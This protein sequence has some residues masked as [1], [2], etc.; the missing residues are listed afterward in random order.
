MTQHFG[1]SAFRT[2]AYN[3][4]IEP[5]AF[6]MLDADDGFGGFA[7]GLLA[8]TS[9]T[10]SHHAFVATANMRLQEGLN[11]DF[12][13]FGASGGLETWSLG[14]GR[15]GL[16][17]GRMA[18]RMLDFG[19]PNNVGD[20]RCA[21]PL[22]ES[23]APATFTGHNET[24]F[25]GPDTVG[26]I[27]P[28]IPP[29]PLI[30]TPDLIPA[31]MT[32]T[33]TLTVNGAHITSTIN[34]VGDHDWFKVDLV[35]GQTYDISQWM[36]TGG[37]SLVPLPDAYISLYDSAGNLIVNADGGGP[38]TPQGLDATLTYTAQYTGTYYVSAEAFDQDSTNGTEGDGV[39]DYEIF[40]RTV[41]PHQAG[42]YRPFYDPDQPM[43]AI[44]WGTQVDG[45]VRNPDGNNGTR[46]NDWAPD[47]TS[48][49]NNTEFGITGKNVITYYFAKTGE[50]YIDEDL[51]TLGTT[52]TM[53]AEGMEQWEKDAFRAALDQYEHVAD[54]IYLETTDRAAADFI[55]ITYEG[56][57]GAGASL[58]GRMSPPDTDNEGQAEFNAGDVRWT[59]EGLQQG[60][61]YFTTLLHEIGH[62]HGMAHP[63]DNG[64]HSSIM[65]GAGP[66]D[67]PVDGAIGGEFGDYDLSQQVFT[68]MSYND[69]WQTSPYGMPS[70]GDFPTAMNAD[71][72][73]WMGTL[74][75]LDIAVIQDK[76]GVNEEY[77]AG[78]NVYTLKDVNAAGTFY[79]TIWDGG[80]TD[81]IR[82]DG[83]ANANLDLR[84]ATLK[85]EYGGG[86]WMN[87]AYGI[88]GGYTIANGVTIENATGGSGNDS[89]TGNDAAN[90]L[91][92]RAGDDTIKAGAG[93][94]ILI[95]GAGTNSL[96]GGDGDDTFRAGSGADAMIGGAGT[97]YADYRLAGALAINL[98]TGF[99]SAA[100][101]G[102]TFNS[103]E[104]FML[105]GGDD[106][107]VVGSTG[108]TVLAGGGEDLLTG[109]SGVDDLR[110][111]DGD[112]IIS[113]ND[114][115]DLVDGGLGADWLKGGNG[116]D[117]I[118]GGDGDDRLEGGAGGDVLK[119]GLGADIL[120]G[121]SGTDTADYRGTDAVSLNLATGVHGGAAAGDTL[122]SIELY[123]LSDAGDT[124]VGGGAADYVWGN[125]GADSLSGGGGADH[126][127]GGAG[128]DVIDGGMGSDELYGGSGADM[129]VFANGFGTDKI[130]DFEDGIDHIKL[131][132][133]TGVTS[134]SNVVVTQDLFGNAVLSFGL[135]NSI[136]LQGVS[137][138]KVDASDFIFN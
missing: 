56:T 54:V 108:V 65:R 44:D 135:N 16:F 28:T 73:G 96:D 2:S 72:Y 33:Q 5:G 121:G 3:A 50:L 82:Y 128:D 120:D 122:T 111:E 58:L 94:D 131:S 64:G 71:P 48:P 81:E 40:V 11:R 77:N 35:A 126:L 101:Q 117:R 80:G 12:G 32:T 130:F 137:A 136:T 9:L 10:A 66:S 15:E 75:A 45:T 102:D 47:G 112:D 42:A 115:A 70:S 24:A 13:R 119:G 27:H 114:G 37:P 61:F 36:V 113:A 118:S 22:K 87:Y 84:A 86:G 26:D 20:G 67:D 91:D 41:D 97:D 89:I 18:G 38:N 57:P 132:G 60:G 107:F 25:P 95:G 76:Y 6:A 83:A 127:E 31:N 99:H 85:Y 124:F 8:S 123:N 74:G 46:P 49:V 14:D 30:L 7:G 105:G 104:V 21:L 43:H 39:G 29:Q 51:T 90:I 125:A 1:V 100:A 93:N 138:A 62:G 52:S 78:N 88:H 55:F 134:F 59:Q 68:V 98:A 110:G 69:G 53:V 116:D 19:G 4:G 109:G 17:G 23:T 63:H 129:F 103:V 79:Q 133:I 106:S 34:T 92:G